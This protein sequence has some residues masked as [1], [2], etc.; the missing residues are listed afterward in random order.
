MSESA[1][2]AIQVYTA[3][4]ETEQ[5]ATDLLPLWKLPGG[6]YF[7]PRQRAACEAVDIIRATTE[8]LVARCKCALSLNTR[9]A[10]LCTNVHHFVVH[11]WGNFVL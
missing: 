1:G 6:R 4:K 2:C 10:S 9:A 11:R 3:L 5:R 7:L 8:E